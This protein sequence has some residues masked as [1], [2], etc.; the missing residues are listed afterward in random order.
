M[1][2]LDISL[3]PGWDKIPFGEGKGKCQITVRRY[4]G[5]VET[6]YSMASGDD[7]FLAECLDNGESWTEIRPMVELTGPGVVVLLHHESGKSPM[8]TFRPR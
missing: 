5:S 1:E 2:I 8:V 3:I 7:D 4:D 6:L